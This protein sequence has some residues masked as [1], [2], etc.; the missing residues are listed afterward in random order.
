[1]SKYA[2]IKGIEGPVA[3]GPVARPARLLDQVE[4]AI[5]RLHYSRGTGEAY[6]H[7]IKRFVL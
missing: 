1:M 3:E 6:A 2:V 5:R 4:D 7:W